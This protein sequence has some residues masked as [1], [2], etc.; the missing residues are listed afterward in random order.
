MK[1]N[2]L[3]LP[4]GI[5]PLTTYGGT[6][7][8]AET[9][10]DNLSHKFNFYVFSRN[11]EFPN[12]KF[13]GTL[14]NSYNTYFL[15]DLKLNFDIFFYISF[16]K[17][18]KISSVIMFGFLNFHVNLIRILLFKL[19]KVKLI[20]APHG[21]I[22][23]P[24]LQIKRIKKV[25][26]FLFKIS[27]IFRNIYFHSTSV[28]ESYQLKKYL[29]IKDNF[30]FQIDNLPKYNQ[31]KFSKT[32]KIEGHL[33]LV[34]ISRIH[35]KKGLKRLI[36]LINKFNDEIELDIYG[37][38]EN[39]KYWD[40]CYSSIKNRNVSYKGKLNYSNVI[41]TFSKYDYFSFLTESENFGH[42]IIE[43]LQANTPIILTKG[44]TPF[45]DL[46][47]FCGYLVN[48]DIEVVELLHKLIN[49]TSDEY[50]KISANCS[51][52]LKQKINLES[53]INQY[54]SLIT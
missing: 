32:N 3:I 2:I 35:P 44:T 20:I 34:F 30:L 23:E 47:N 14:K 10:I 18:H 9:L 53:S 33:K 21:E 4:G 51:L 13:N 29:S 27:G 54:N 50:N 16:I 45:D 5:S 12:K 11:K 15:N 28:S 40:E 17:K 36:N 43:S 31:F 38:I 1:K 24:I 37:I 48:D 46:N 41:N 8:S 42:V 19:L 39:K 25:V 6:A 52:Y 22:E 26:L 49:Q 7:K